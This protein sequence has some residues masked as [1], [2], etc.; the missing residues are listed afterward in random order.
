MGEDGRVGSACCKVKWNDRRQEMDGFGAS[1]AFHQGGH[2]LRYPEPARTAMLDLLF[3][4]ERGIGLSIERNIIGDSGVW[5]DEIDGPTVS[6]EPSEGVWSWTGDEE[7][8]TLMREAALRGCTRFMSTAWSPPAWMKTNNC[9]IDG[10]ELREDQY[11]AFADY[12]SRY[13][14]GYKEHHGLDIYAISPTNEPDLTI[15]YSSCRWTGAQLRDFIKNYLAPAL[16]RDGVTAKVIMPEM[17]K[18]SEEYAV[19]ALD[20]PEA[21]TAI[22]IIGTHAYDYSKNAFPMSKQYGKRIW[23]TEICAESEGEWTITDALR[24]A[25]MVHEHMTIT[26]VSAWNYWWL[27][28][29]KP[30]QGGGLIQLD[31]QAQTY[32]VLKTTYVF[33]NYSRFVR[34]GWTRI[35]AT[36]EPDKGVLV[37]AYRAGTGDAFAIVAVNIGAEP[38]TIEFRLDEFPATTHVSPFRTSR[39]EDLAPLP[40][41]P[42]QS[43]AFVTELLGESVTTFVENGQP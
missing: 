12:L 31:L 19:E 14:T 8:I 15:G 29:C 18:L 38:A 28:S 42:I 41:V 22:D 26:G 5:G 9:V 11:Q 13:V 2:I 43:G 33:G 35:D 30:K 27:A 23:Q 16:A 20:D 37:T 10:G 4:P 40:T 24:I 3:S 36:A 32:K 17:T 7:Q 21:C 39:D 6:I 1:G 34:P 25:T